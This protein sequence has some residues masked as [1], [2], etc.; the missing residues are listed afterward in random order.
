MRGNGLDGWFGWP[1]SPRLE[2]LRDRWFDAPDEAAQRVVCEEMQRVAFEEVPFL[3][4]GQ[5]FLPTAVRDS[6]TGIVKAS[7]PVFWGVKR[8]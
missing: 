5:R 1:T 4:V 7:Y 6:L 2:A 3:P 8:A